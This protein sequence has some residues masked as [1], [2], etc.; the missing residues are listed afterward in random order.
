MQGV[1]ASVV[2]GVGTPDVVLT[3]MSSVKMVAMGSEGKT[4]QE[5]S[6]QAPSSSASR[7]WE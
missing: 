5:S 2:P 1:S 6:R 7:A 4:Y 3:V